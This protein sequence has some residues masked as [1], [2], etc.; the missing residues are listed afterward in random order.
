MV[1]E[2]MAKI[3][4]SFSFEKKFQIDL[5]LIDWIIDSVKFLYF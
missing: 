1:I 5:D 4:L 3:G 2:S